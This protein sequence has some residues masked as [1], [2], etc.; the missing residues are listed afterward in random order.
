[1]HGVR[2]RREYLKSFGKAEI[3]RDPDGGFRMTARTL[4]IEK[5]SELRSGPEAGVYAIDSWSLRQRNL[6]RALL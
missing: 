1:M 5:W 4:Y 2:A 3:A 6:V